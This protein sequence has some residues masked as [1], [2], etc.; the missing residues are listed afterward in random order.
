MDSC[1]WAWPSTTTTHSRGQTRGCA[2]TS[3]PPRGETDGR[4]DAAVAAVAADA[5]DAGDRV[6]EVVDGEGFELDSNPP[7]GETDGRVH[8][9][10][11][12]EGFEL[13]SNPPRGETGDGRDVD[14]SAGA[15]DA[16]RVDEVVDGDI[17]DVVGF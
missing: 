16:G 3:N 7:R 14:T 2:C 13:D 17:S 15:A 1:A 4:D 8:E 5:A 6:D 11:D 10:V 9:V 12:G